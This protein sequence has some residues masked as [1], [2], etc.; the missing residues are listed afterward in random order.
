M[1]S[2]KV[3]TILAL[4][5]GEQR[6]GVAEANSIARIA[7]PL[8]TLTHGDTILTDIAQLIKKQDATMLVVG[9]P[10]GMQSQDTQQ[11]QYVRDFITSLQVTVSTPVF[12]QDEALTSHK[13]EEELKARKK[14]F[15]KGDV[16]ALAAT[17]ILDDF[18]QGYNG[19]W[20]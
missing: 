11:T 5:V 3:V 8:T 13:A 1:Q 10:R 2:S 9:L 14:P 4:D 6:I 12:W 20:I 18:L 15:A 7:H 16:D 19:E 17:Y